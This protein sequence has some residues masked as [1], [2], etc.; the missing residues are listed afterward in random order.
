MRDDL[1][2]ELLERPEQIR[3][4]PPLDDPAAALVV[5]AMSGQISEGSERRSAARRIW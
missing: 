5:A 3:S 4:T 2:A 1:S